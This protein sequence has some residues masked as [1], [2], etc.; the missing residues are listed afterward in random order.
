M[1]HAFKSAKREPTTALINIVFLILIFFMVAGTLS[2]P[3]DT[4]IE[5]VSTEGL[6]CCIDPDALTISRDGAMSLDG[7]PITSFAQVIAAADKI[8]PVVRIA[9][10]QNLPAHQLLAIVR[11]LEEAGFS[12]ITIVTETHA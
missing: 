3:K 7:A 4:S 10:D 6:E 9:P 1:R 11:E 2:G 12:E 8:N 5:F